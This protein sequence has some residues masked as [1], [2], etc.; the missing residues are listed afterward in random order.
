MFEKKQ[1][2][3]NLLIPARLEFELPDEMIRD[4]KEIKNLKPPVEEYLRTM[5][6]IF[7]TYLKS[8]GAQN[9]HHQYF[10]P[11]RPKHE[12]N[13]LRK[14]GLYIAFKIPEENLDSLMSRATYI[15]YPFSLRIVKDK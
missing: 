5:E 13:D 7:D 9:I 11:E 1:V 12:K 4:V 10:M 14:T 6:W 3:G 15:R 8:Y 2:Q